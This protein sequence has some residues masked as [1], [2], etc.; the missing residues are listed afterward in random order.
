MISGLIKRPKENM[1]PDFCVGGWGAD[2]VV[3]GGGATFGQ[4]GA[5]TA[6][7]DVSITNDPGGRIVEFMLR[8]NF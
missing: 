2:T 5:G 4:P 3:L 6:Y 7:Q 8:I 1:M